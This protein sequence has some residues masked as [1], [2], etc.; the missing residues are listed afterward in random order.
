MIVER[1]HKSANT[2]PLWEPVFI[3]FLFNLSESTSLN[4]SSEK[5][6]KI[7]CC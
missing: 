2:V 7:K 4:F 5:E 3:L 6:F 1:G